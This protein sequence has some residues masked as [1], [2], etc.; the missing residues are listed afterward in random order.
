[1]KWQ[2]ILFYRTIMCSFSVFVQ[3]GPGRFLISCKWKV[4]RFFMVNLRLLIVFFFFYF[5]LLLLLM[6]LFFLTFKTSFSIVS[7]QFEHNTHIQKE[8]I[9]LHD[10]FLF[11]WSLFIC[12]ISLP[13]NAHTHTHIDKETW[14]RHLCDN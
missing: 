14:Y 8:W 9:W 4:E 3:L 7:I 10:N 6:L 5:L 2:S 12:W 13:T 1:M 11:A